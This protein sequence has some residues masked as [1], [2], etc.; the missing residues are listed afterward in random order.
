MKK[1]ALISLYFG[2]YPSNFNLW[3]KSAEKNKDIDF[4][5]YGDCDTSNLEIYPKNVRFVKISFEEIKRKIQNCFDFQIVLDEP[6]KLCDYKPAYGLVFEKD[7]EGYD[8]WGHFDID[9]ILGDICKFLPKDDYEK[10]Y[11][12]GHMIL[13]KNSPENNRRFMADVGMNYK[14]VYTTSFSMIFDELPGMTKKYDLLGAS[15]CKDVYFADIAR[16]RVNFTLNEEI[17]NRDNYKYQI[18]YYDSGKV[19][20]DYVDDGVIKTDEFSYIHFSHRDMPDK[21]NGATSYYVTRFGCIE[22]TGKTTADVI[23]EL[24][25]PTPVRNIFCWVDCQIIRRIKRGFSYLKSKC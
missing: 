2:E 10:I 6:Y 8:Y 17:C 11:C 25:N 12:F 19:L 1:I 22:K 9:T 18:F 15:Q 5:M 20:R 7:V 23:K 13:Y 3:L 16:R 24:N 14:D 21:T 4:L